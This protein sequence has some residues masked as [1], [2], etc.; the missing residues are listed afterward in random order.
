M[1]PGRNDPC[2]CGS[3]KKYKKCCDGKVQALSADQPLPLR[4]KTE[5]AALN[6]PVRGVMPTPVEM[7]QLVA[8]FN[9]GR[10]V[11]F[12]SSARLLLEQYP[13]SGFA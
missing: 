10:Y 5:A 13:D 1:K 3:G 12:E 9:A 7:N 8:L 6:N 4:Q 11:E 2:L